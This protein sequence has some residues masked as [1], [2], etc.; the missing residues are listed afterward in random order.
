MTFTILDLAQFCYAGKCDS[1]FKETL[2]NNSGVSNQDTDMG[3]LTELVLHLH[4]YQHRLV[5]EIAMV[6]RSPEQ[7]T[8][9]SVQ[10]E[11]GQSVSELYMNTIYYGRAKSFW[12]G[13]MNGLASLG[14]QQL[15]GSDSRLLIQ[16]QPHDSVVADIKHTLRGLKCAL[17]SALKSPEKESPSVYQLFT[18]VSPLRCINYLSLYQEPPVK[19]LDMILYSVQL[20]PTLIKSLI[21]THENYC[22]IIEV[23]VFELLYFELQLFSILSLKII[24]IKWLGSLGSFSNQ[25]PILLNQ[26]HL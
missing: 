22:G 13:R 3:I 5:K 6:M 20:C 10:L 19:L 7:W 18:F 25:S 4:S 12:I 26:L 1:L 16:I 24:Y 21:H 14:T 9:D 23:I 11:A 8:Q 15:T 17:E 2:L